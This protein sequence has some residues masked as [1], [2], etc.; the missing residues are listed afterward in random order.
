MQQ[1][2]K[3][4]YLYANHLRL[5]PSVFIAPNDDAGAS[6]A[7]RVFFY[8]TFTQRKQGAA[9]AVHVVLIHIITI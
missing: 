2:L 8:H 3:R 9:Y 5:C 4:P 6:Y 7:I 1:R